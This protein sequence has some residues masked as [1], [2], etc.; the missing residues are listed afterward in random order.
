[1]LPAAAPPT[2]SPSH[3]SSAAVGHRGVLAAA[4]RAEPPVVADVMASAATVASA[5]PAIARPAT[6]ENL[7]IVILR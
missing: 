5:A 2:P 6:R 1:V 3:T 7:F 4:A